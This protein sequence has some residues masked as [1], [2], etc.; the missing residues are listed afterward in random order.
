MR[1]GQRQ[2]VM[3]LWR[4]LRSWELVGCSGVPWMGNGERGPEEEGGDKRPGDDR[5]DDEI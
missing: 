1:A 3:R 5:S 2:D 4:N